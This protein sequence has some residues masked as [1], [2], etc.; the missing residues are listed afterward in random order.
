MA[1]EQ[2]ASDLKLSAVTIS[3]VTLATI[4]ATG[5]L[6]MPMARVADFRGRMFVYNVGLAGFA[7]FC[8]ASAFAPNAA[9]LILT[10]ALQGVAA[11]F[12]FSTTVAMVTLSYPPEHAG[13]LSACRWPGS[14]WGSPWVRCWAASSP[15]TS[16]GGG[17]SSWSERSAS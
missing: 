10:R 4:L 1:L 3:W 8:F 14:T 16:A 6:L 15:R 13:G 5:A 11:A 7:V 17:S 2:I 9:V 12:L